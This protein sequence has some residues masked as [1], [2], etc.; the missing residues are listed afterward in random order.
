M[1]ILWIKMECQC[2]I[3]LARFNCTLLMIHS[4]IHELDK[5]KEFIAQVSNHVTPLRTRH[6]IGDIDMQIM[7]FLVDRVDT[8][9]SDSDLDRV[10]RGFGSADDG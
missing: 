8:S 5:K 6:S 2:K 4:N 9:L 7:S 3:C 1:Q 10:L